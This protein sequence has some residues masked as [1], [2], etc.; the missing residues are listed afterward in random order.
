MSNPAPVPT[1]ADVS[2]YYAEKMRLLFEQ[3]EAERARP[4]HSL[5]A[6]GVGSCIR[7]GAYKLA[8]TPPD[9]RAARPGSRT[10][11]MGTAWHEFSLPRLARLC[12]PDAKDEEKTI[13]RA[14]GIGITGHHDLYDPHTPYGPA[15][16]DM[17]TLGA[18][19]WRRITGGGGVP[20]THRIQSY[21]YALG[22]IQADR[23]VRWVTWIY[24]DRDTGNEF[25]V[26][27]PFD[28]DSAVEAID[29][30]TNIVRAAESPDTAPREEVGPSV[31]LPS[32]SWTPCDPCPWV[33]RCW[34]TP[35]DGVAAQATLATEDT[36]DGEVF[37][38]RYYTAQQAE[39]AAKEEKE[40]ARAV[41]SGVKT[42]TY[43]P[44]DFSRTKTGSIR[45]KPGK[46]GK[47]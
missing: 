30:V 3:E 6:S 13:A 28:A 9:D 7:Q 18:Y 14:A 40:F 16:V 1:P 10:A 2:A 23:P 39:A 17:K 45:I 33:V 26:T 47:T 12:G 27:E 11:T 24:V 8:G 38:R 42:G 35:V 37:V 19:M 43:G 4:V 20:Y 31:W 21:L 34:G 46:G 22:A 15:I 5:S 32:R 41:L 25:V 44:L 29:R 36:G